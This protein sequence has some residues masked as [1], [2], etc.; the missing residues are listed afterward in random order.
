MILK[1]DFLEP[2]VGLSPRSQILLAGDEKHAN[3]FGNGPN[4]GITRGD[5]Q[6]V[7]A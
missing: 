5:L 6:M 7:L 1:I 4:A 3:D 2:S